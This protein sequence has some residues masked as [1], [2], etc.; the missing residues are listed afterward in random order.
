MR[1]GW[2]C[3]L[4]VAA[5][6]MACGSPEAPSTPPGEILGRVEVSAGV[7]ASGCLVLVEGAPISAR[8]DDGGAFDLRNMPPG[9]WDLRIEPN[10]QTHTLPAR[11]IAAGANSNFVSDLGAIQLSRPGSV[12]GHV[13]GDPAVL[14]TSYIA[15]PSIGAVTA[16]NAGGGYLIENVS[17]GVHDII[18]ITPSGA[19]DQ[20]PVVVSPDHVTINVNFDLGAVAVAGVNVH[21]VAS[22]SDGTTDG[23]RVE[24]VGSLDGNVVQTVHPGDGGVFAFAGTEPGAYLVRAVDDGNPAR[25]I[26]PSVVVSGTQDVALGSALI[27]PIGNDLD[28]DGIPDSQ[29][30]DIDGDGVPN[31]MDAFPYDPAETLDTDGDGVGDR[32]D[33]RSLGGGNIDTNNPTPDTDHDGLLDFEDNCPKVPNANQNDADR[34]GVGDACDSCPTLPNPDQMGLCVQ[35]LTNDQCGND[36]CDVGLCV[37]CTATSQCTGGRTC[38]T[39]LG[40]CVACVTDPDCGDAT[41]ACLAGVCTPKCTLD[42]QCPGGVCDAGVCVQCRGTADC[43]INQYC[44]QHVCSAKCTSS[45]QCAGARTCD[46]V[47]GTCVTPCSGTC[48]TGDKC[49]ANVCR[50]ACDGSNPC[51]SGETCD[52]ATGA[53]KPECAVNADCAAGGFPHAVCN[54]GAC[55]PDG[56]CA[57][58]ADCADSEMCVAG[59]CLARP[60]TFDPGQG[61]RCTTACDCRQ[62]EVC[63]ATGGHCVDDAVTFGDGTTRTL[64]PTFFAAAGATGTGE[65]PNLPG[66]PAVGLSRV[67]AGNQAVLAIRGGDTIAIGA[68][69]APTQGDVAVLGGYQVCA[70]NRWVRDAAQRT[71]I[72]SAVTTGVQITGT[73]SAPLPHIVL[74]GLA[75]TSTD[76]DPNHRRVMVDAAFAPAL[77]IANATLTQTIGPSNSPVTYG[78]VICDHCTGVAFANIVVGGGT[79]NDNVRF[80]GISL[81]SGSGTIDRVH[82]AAANGTTEIRGIEVSATTGPVVITGARIDAMASGGGT[83]ILVNGCGNDTATGTSF[84]VTIATS[85][86]G[87]ND[88]SPGNQ[89]GWTGIAVVSCQTASVH[90][91]TV[92]GNGTTLDEGVQHDAVTFVD[93]SGAIANVHVVFPD[94]IQ[95]ARLDGFHLIGP[96]GTIAMTGD[97]TA[98]GHFINGMFIEVENVT[99][100]VITISGGN[101]TGTAIETVVGLSV[102]GSANGGNPA[103][104]VT[105]VSIVAH[106]TSSN[107]GSATGLALSSSIARVERSTIMT[108]SAPSNDTVVVGAVSGLEIYDS[109][110]HADAGANKN[111]VAMSVGAAA[112]LL[113]VGDTFETGGTQ[114]STTTY[115]MQCEQTGVAT[116]RSTIFGGGAGIDHAMVAGSNGSGCYTNGHFDHDYFWYS[117]PN[118]GHGTAE[119]VSTVVTTA[120]GIKDANGN[121]VNDNVSCYDPAFVQPDFHL[122]SGSPCI[123]GGVAGTRKDGSAIAKDITNGA[124]VKGA[125]A[126]IGAFEKE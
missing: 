16:P 19:R 48:A 81:P 100:G 124:R 116:V 70:S 52:S 9:R 80:K 125:A 30:D 29:D 33:L 86:V 73:S 63:D 37:P 83:G 111:A 53:C 32:A 41:K 107:A 47:T 49:V 120:V 65:S 108:G 28:G 62:G 34:D 24:L 13:T 72:A 18:L 68:A 79:S 76:S 77:V 10:D 117:R 55:V 5:T 11:R 17:P 99:Q 121:E 123:N 98:G 82:V 56:T 57:F 50:A 20:A 122:A 101:Y 103:V 118:A 59:V 102:V 54:A 25:A 36:I 61:F 26:I 27:I 78:G 95:G 2:S 119:V 75:L 4:V 92:D 14:A 90:D 21:G 87:W 44:D 126:D 110:V 104:T 94:Q 6:L 91:D 84:P 105:D 67:V 40:V 15:V 1:Q 38:N 114:A 88:R 112:S 60:T 113:A 89:V 23:V 39:A 93:S 115:A 71:T 46:L 66:D 64:T 3:S 51:A 35:C 45:G 106:G 22:H 42:T 109:F 58:D 43:P 31:A 97:T 8:C 85:T 7:P 74:E 96:R 69:I 12:G